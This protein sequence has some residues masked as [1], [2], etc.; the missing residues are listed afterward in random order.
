VNFRFQA[1]LC[2]WCQKASFPR[3]HGGPRFPTVPD[4]KRASS[5]KS[6]KARLSTGRR[7][8]MTCSSEDGKRSS[9]PPSHAENQH[10]MLHIPAGNSFLSCPYLEF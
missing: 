3:E 4:S 6:K 8:V 1:L 10:F 7:K 9:V 5:S 2:C